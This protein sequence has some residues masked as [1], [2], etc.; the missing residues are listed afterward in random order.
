MNINKHIQSYNHHHDQDVESSHHAKNSPCP[1]VA[2][3][4]LLVST[5]WLSVAIILMFPECHINGIIQCIYSCLIQDFLTSYCAFEIC[6]RWITISSSFLTYVFISVL[7]Y[8][9]TT[10]YLLSSWWKFSLCPILIIK[11]RE[12]FVYGFSVIACF[13]F[14]CVNT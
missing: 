2:P 5:D 14:S 3:L 7:F 6:Q 13:Y 10:V 9:C 12:E 8:R 4:L 1:F 11:P